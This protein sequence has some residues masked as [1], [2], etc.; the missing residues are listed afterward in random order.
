MPVTSKVARH[1]RASMVGQLG[2]GLAS[3]CFRLQPQLYKLAG[4]NQLR[5]LAIFL[6]GSLSVFA[7]RRAAKVVRFRA[8]AIVSV[9]PWLKL[10][11]IIA[12]PCP[13]ITRGGASYPKPLAWPPVA[14]RSRWPTIPPAS[15]S[16]APASPLDPV[17]GL[18]QNGPSRGAKL[19]P[20]YGVSPVG[21][22]RAVVLVPESTL[23]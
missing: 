15:A 18:I 11:P 22:P 21:R 4:S 9:Q 16:A 12:H 3:F 14:P 2:A 20:F 17:F 10:I 8:S 19:R 1:L 5:R 23:F 7:L 6:N 13:S